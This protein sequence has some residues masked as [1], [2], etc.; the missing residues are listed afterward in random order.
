M[1]ATTCKRKKRLDVDTPG[2]WDAISSP[3]RFE[4][5][6]CLE[7]AGPCSVAELANLMAVPADSLYHHIKILHKSGLIQEAGFR[8]SGRQIEAVYDV[9]ADQLIFDLEAD[10]N[11]ERLTKLN[12]AALRQ[13]SRTLKSAMK[14]GVAST[15]GPGRNTCARLETAWLSR[16][17]LAEVRRHVEAISGI[18]AA[19]RT[20]RSGQLMMAWCCLSPVVR[21]RRTRPE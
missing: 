6:A 12:D 20:R 21:G 8:K 19:G 10:G 11:V 2:Q 13:C 7:G 5:Y 18:F 16:E 17:E 14:R 15:R 1:A 9:T 4:M 3:V